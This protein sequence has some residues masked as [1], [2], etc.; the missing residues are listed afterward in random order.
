MEVLKMRGTKIP[1]KTFEMDIANKGIIVNP[2]K[3]V[4]F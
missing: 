2:S 3:V 4:D 1:E